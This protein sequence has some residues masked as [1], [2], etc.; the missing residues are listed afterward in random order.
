[1]IK[2]YLFFVSVFAVYGGL[3]WFSVRH[4]QKNAKLIFLMSS[5][6]V[7]SGVVVCMHINLFFALLGAALIMGFA[8]YVSDHEITTS[9]NVIIN[10]AFGGLWLTIPIYVYLIAN[11]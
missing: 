7:F 10:G 8:T 2:Y 5:L 3:Y 1:M 6:G 9:G 4:K 11:A